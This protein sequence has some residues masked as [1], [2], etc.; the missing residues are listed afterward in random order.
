M[1]SIRIATSLNI[2]DFKTFILL[3]HQITSLMES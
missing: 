3:L 1:K 2:Y